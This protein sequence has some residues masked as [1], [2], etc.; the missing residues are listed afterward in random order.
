MSDVSLAEIEA[1]E[2]E[3]ERRRQTIRRALFWAPL[4][5]AVLM[6]AVGGLSLWSASSGQE[7]DRAEVAVLVEERQTEA[8]EAEEEL[9]AAWSD[10]LARS[11]AVRVERLENDSEAMRILLSEAVEEGEDVSVELV[12][13][14]DEEPPALFEELRRDGV[15][16]L[17]GSAQARLGP[18]EPVLTGIEGMDYTY[19]TSVDIHGADDEE[20]RSIASLSVEWTTDTDGAVTEIDA[21][22]T[23]GAPERS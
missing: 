11:S 10:A 17:D 6:L 1:Y 7:A 12:G 5:V 19:F 3:R 2:R 18:F 22:W 21:H 20:E 9:H 16:G 4:G 14:E 23:E 15:P 8:R 13:T